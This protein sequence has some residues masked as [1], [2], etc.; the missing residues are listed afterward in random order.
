M[1]NN[2]RLCISTRAALHMTHHGRMDILSG[3]N[4]VTARMIGTHEEGRMP[5]VHYWDRLS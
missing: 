4:A 5:L 2:A 3:E 1:W